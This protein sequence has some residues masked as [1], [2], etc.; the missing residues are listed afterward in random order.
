[1]RCNNIPSSEVGRDGR[2]EVKCCFL[3]SH[4][5]SVSSSLS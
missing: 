1:M 2:G 5:K 3:M 4:G